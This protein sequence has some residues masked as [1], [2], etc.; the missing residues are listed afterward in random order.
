[1][2]EQSQ[3]SFQMYETVEQQTLYDTRIKSVSNST[4]I[5]TGKTPYDPPIPLHHNTWF[6]SIASKPAMACS[7]WF[8]NSSH[9]L[10]G[11]CFPAFPVCLIYIFHELHIVFNIRSP[12]L[13]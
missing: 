4:K 11:L 7:E 13:D 10:Q 6:K 5:K 9:H 1:M 2:P 3:I 12:N 8:S